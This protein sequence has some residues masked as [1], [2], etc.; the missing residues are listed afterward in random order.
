MEKKNSLNCSRGVA[1]TKN[2][3]KIKSIKWRRHSTSLSL[4][5]SSSSS[6]H[7]DLLND[8][9]QKWSMY[10]KTEKLELLIGKKSKWAFF[11]ISDFFLQTFAISKQKSH[12]FQQRRIWKIYCR[13]FKW[14]WIFYGSGPQLISLV[15]AFDEF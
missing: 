14:S 4:I 13:D 10:W 7:F 9:H 3:H 2:S 11:S 6:G 5:A 15:L 1:S 12:D 8:F